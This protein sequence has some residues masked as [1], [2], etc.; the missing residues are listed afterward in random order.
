MGDQ[1]QWHRLARLI[2]E[3]RE[4]ADAA[5]TSHDGAAAQLDVAEYDLLQIARTL[6][7]VMRTVDGQPVVPPRDNAPAAAPRKTVA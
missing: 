7:E 1:S 3:A 2:E 5:A 6:G 4:R